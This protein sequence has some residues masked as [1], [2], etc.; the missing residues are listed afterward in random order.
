MMRMRLLRMDLRA[1]FKRPGMC[2]FSTTNIINIMQIANGERAQ[3]Q[4]DRRWDAMRAIVRLDF[5][6]FSCSHSFQ[7]TRLFKSLIPIPCKY[8]PWKT[9]IFLFFQPPH[10]KY[11]CSGSWHNFEIINNNNQLLLLQDKDVEWDDNGF[12]HSILQ[13]LTLIVFHVHS[14]LSERTEFP[15]QWSLNTIMIMGSRRAESLSKNIHIPCRST[16][17]SWISG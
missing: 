10:L 8:A 16:Y 7:S 15:L 3:Q 12:E 9:C 6:S 1:A 11:C 17:I 5:P 13:L 2:F 4:K 14:P